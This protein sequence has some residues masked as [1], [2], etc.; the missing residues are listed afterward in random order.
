MGKKNKVKEYVPE[1]LKSLETFLENV[2]QQGSKKMLKSRTNL[3]GLQ[4]AIMLLPKEHRENIEKFWGLTGGPNHSKRMSC[5]GVKDMAYF[6]MMNKSIKSL[7][8][9]RKLDYT[10]IYDES[11]YTLINLINQKLNKDGIS[12]VSDLE[13]A[14]YLLAFFVVVQNGP[15][16]SFEIDLMTVETKV[17]K[18]CYLD[19]YEALHQVCQEL[20]DVPDHSINMGL[21]K[22]IFDMMD[23]KDCVAIQKSF[24]ID[25]TRHFGPDETEILNAFQSDKTEDIHTFGQIR[26]FKE[27]AFEYGAWD[28]TYQLI[29]GSPVELEEFMKKIEI[30]HRDWSKISD[31][32]TSQKNLRTSSSTRT[33]DVYSI[34]G[35]EFTDPYEVMF[36]YL[37]RNLIAC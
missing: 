36:L 27:R 29:I 34:G 17:D 32:K 33:L 7:E 3:N 28:V 21:V 19:E 1:A 15:K 37:E 24:G 22:S 9:L 8:H 30:L 5:R 18:L 6:E 20:K 35:L 14:K 31:F 16:M 11:V 10:S 4:K 12:G 2:R 23:L 26:S 13:C 25:F